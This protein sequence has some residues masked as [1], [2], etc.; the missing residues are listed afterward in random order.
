MP[1]AARVWYQKHMTHHMLPHYGLEWIDGL[2][3]CFLIR[4]PAAVIASYAA[5]REEVTAADL[6]YHRQVALFDR[7]AD[8]TGAPPPV[9]DSQDILRDPQ[10]MLTA[11]CARIGIPFDPAM[12]SWPAGRR[13]SDGVWGA[14]WYATVEASTGFM[15][16][17]EMPATVPDRL[18]PVYEDC[19]DPYTALVK[20]RLIV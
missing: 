15:P 17:V 14:H 8:R 7:V 19:L 10:A 4:D 11:L 16:P 20:H 3:N 18:M 9:V 13:D 1:G 6:G 5:K 2:K 12:L